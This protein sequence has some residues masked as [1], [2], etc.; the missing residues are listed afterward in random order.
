M[1]IYQFR[2]VVLL[3]L[4]L[5]CSLVGLAATS[6]SRN[7]SSGG[8]KCLLEAKIVVFSTL[9]RFAGRRRVDLLD[10]NEFRVRGG[11]V[12]VATVIFIQILIGLLFDN[13]DGFVECCSR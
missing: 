9:M 4:S 6:P 13:F 12:A 7:R 10:K 1:R 3:R 11:A 5:V 8:T 2:G